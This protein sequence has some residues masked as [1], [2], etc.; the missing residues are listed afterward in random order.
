[1]SKLYLPFLLI[2]SLIVCCIEVDISVPSFPEIGHYFHVSESIVQLTIAF[3]FLGFCLSSVVFGPLSECY[4]RRK[5]MIIGN[6]ILLIGA[7]SCVFASS[8]NILLLAR[9]VQG[10]GASTSAV[11]VFAMIADL[12]QGAKAVKLI[13]IMN[14][15]LTICIA[16]A[17]VIGGF[18]NKI[19]G[20][21]GNYACVAF[22]S[23]I[24]WI[25][26]IGFLP[27]TK[28]KPQVFSFKKVLKEYRDVLINL[29][30]F[31][32]SMVPSL[33]YSAYM[34]FVA[35]ASF[36]YMKTFGLPVMSYVFHQFVMISFFA[37]TSIF[38]GKLIQLLGNKNCVLLGIG[39]GF[40]G[41]LLLVILSTVAPHSSSLTTISMII[42]LLGFS[43]SYPII[44]TYSLEIFPE[45]KGIASSTIMAV[46][47]FLVTIIVSLNSYFYNGHPIRVA[48]VIVSVMLFVVILTMK[49]MQN[50]S[51][52]TKDNA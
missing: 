26:L 49:L 38:W 45:L 31:C 36:L 25:L 41:S 32:A 22:I 44:F 6:A 12:Y 47:A 20:W 37:I 19:I 2:L 52:L 30:F 1:M 7:T 43:I 23:F 51:F 34:S 28:E 42:F 27:E 46:R 40:L 48:F 35:C 3:N 13:G 18:V 4:G 8:I 15:I 5:I 9:F 17:P 21:R 10:I 33:M 11:V 14:S 16:I 29:K 39:L 50:H 24:S